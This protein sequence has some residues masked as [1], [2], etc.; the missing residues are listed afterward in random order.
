MHELV[1]GTSSA[2][3]L[4]GEGNANAVFGYVGTAPALIG[5][6]IRIRKQPAEAATDHTSDSLTKDL[7]GRT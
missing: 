7:W 2:W 5:R 6:V 1:L 4:K 3:V